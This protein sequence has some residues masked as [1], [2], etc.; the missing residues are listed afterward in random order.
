MVRC[1]RTAYSCGERCGR[2]RPCGHACESS[3]HEGPECPPC[4]VRVRCS[5]RARFL[6]ACYSSS[7]HGRASGEYARQTGCRATDGRHASV[8]KQLRRCWIVS[9]EPSIAAPNVANCYTAAFIGTPFAAMGSPVGAYAFFGSCAQKCHVAPCQP[10]P[11]MGR[12]SCPCGKTQYALKCDAKPP[13]K[14]NNP[15]NKRVAACG[16]VCQALCHDGPCDCS[17]AVTKMCRCGATKKQVITV[18]TA[19]SIVAFLTWCPSGRALR[20]RNRVQQPMRQRSQLWQAQ[21]SQ[22]VLRRRLRPLHGNVW[23]QAV[24]WQSCKAMR[25]RV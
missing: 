6:I 17:L 25:V 3:C 11:L 16:H 2:P 18:A 20:C 13:P 7:R 15:C 9:W 24:V 10:C 5:A 23:W 4:P 19:R 8:A 21:V 14:C 12:R 1:G 22:E